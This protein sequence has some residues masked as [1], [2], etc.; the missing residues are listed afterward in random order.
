MLEHLHGQ[1]HDPQSELDNHIKRQRGFM[2]LMAA[3]MIG[4]LL[5]FA[6]SGCS[7]AQ[8]TP[9]RE[10][11]GQEQQQTPP[12]TNPKQN[13]EPD[14]NKGNTDASANPSKASS[15]VERFKHL[16]DAEPSAPKSTSET[17]QPFTIVSYPWREW[18]TSSEIS[19]AYGQ[20]PAL[21]KTLPDRGVD[22]ATYLSLRWKFEMPADKAWLPLLDRELTYAFGDNNRYLESAA[23]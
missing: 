5:F 18:R 7:K 22:P 1:G 23:T 11:V 6:F 9:A 17:T 15:L 12:D 19:G 4:A 13:Q 21:L 8:P 3:I 10:K 16:I 2:W 14:T 20:R